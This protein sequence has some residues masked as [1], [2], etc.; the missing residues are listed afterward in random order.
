MQNKKGTCI[1]PAKFS[2]ILRFSINLGIVN[3][4]SQTKRAM[5]ILKGKA[6]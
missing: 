4:R 2:G 6:F 5:H 1:A 3:N